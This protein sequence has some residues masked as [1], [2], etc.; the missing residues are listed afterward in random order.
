M[1]YNGCNHIKSKNAIFKKI[2][3]VK[4]QNCYFQF[5][6]NINQGPLD[7]ETMNNIDAHE[8]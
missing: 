4:T 2:W 1:Q 5:E 3:R 6:V 7:F 8:N